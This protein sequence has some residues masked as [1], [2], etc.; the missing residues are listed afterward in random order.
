M[1]EGMSDLATTESLA[2]A[3]FPASEGGQR[4]FLEQVLN[5]RTARME[6]PT[7]RE[8]LFGAAGLLSFGFTAL[9]MTR[10]D[11]AAIWAAGGAAVLHAASAYLAWYQRR[12]RAH[13]GAEPHPSACYRDAQGGLRLRLDQD[14]RVLH[15]AAADGL[16]RGGLR[17]TAGLFHV[18]WGLLLGGLPIAAAGG[19]SLGSPVLLLVTAATY[20]GTFF[21]GRGVMS[22]LAVKPVERVVLT[23][24]RIAVL[25]A[26]GAAESVSL[27]TLHNRPIVVGREGGTATVALATKALPATRPLSFPGLF[28]MHSLDDAEARAWAGAAMDARRALLG[29]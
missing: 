19:I 6:L 24:K 12:G 2:A 25:A 29:E 17:R 14:E 9:S 7:R 13:A 27:R 22:L 16:V 23:N 26:P 21:F 20:L 28:G 5:R 1:G 4:S 3:G 10:G 11:L 18:V 15:E 8:L